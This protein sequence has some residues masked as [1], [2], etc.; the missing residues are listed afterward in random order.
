MLD[1]QLNADRSHLIGNIMLLQYLYLDGSSLYLHQLVSEPKLQGEEP[2]FTF[3]QDLQM[4]PGH[5]VTSTIAE[6]LDSLLA[7]PLSSF[8][9]AV[10]SRHI[11][12]RQ[13]PRG[14]TSFCL[15]E[16]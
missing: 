5:V 3:Q 12:L 6:A 2:P 1:A 14:D 9:G 10:K 16:D 11:C 15:V 4:E 8:N 7:C 13:P